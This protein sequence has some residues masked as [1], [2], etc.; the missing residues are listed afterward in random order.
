MTVVDVKDGRTRSKK[1]K[2]D[3]ELLDGGED[4]LVSEHSATNMAKL[5]FEANIIEET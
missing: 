3:V 2:G 4:D 1:R 5:Q